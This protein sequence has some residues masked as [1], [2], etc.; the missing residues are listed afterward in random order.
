MEQKETADDGTFLFMLFKL[1]DITKKSSGVS[2]IRNK[3]DLSFLDKTRTKISFQRI[4]TFFHNVSEEGKTQI[5]DQHVSQ[6][7][8]LISATDSY[9]GL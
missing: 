8:H 1:N 3:G 7:L 4:T 6:I 9:S 5:K 2:F